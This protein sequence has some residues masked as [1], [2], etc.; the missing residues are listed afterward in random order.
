MVRRLA[1]HNNASIA[2]DRCSRRNV[3]ITYFQ[4]AGLDYNSGAGVVCGCQLVF[5]GIWCCSCPWARG[6]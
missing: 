5:I 3:M 6:A 4:G 1:G 2:V